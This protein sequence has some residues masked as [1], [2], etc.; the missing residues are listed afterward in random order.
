MTRNTNKA[1]HIAFVKE[2]VEMAS[3]ILKVF[4]KKY[5]KDKRPR[6]AIEAAKDWL[7]NP[8]EINRKAAEKAYHAVPGTAM[9]WTPADAAEA[10]CLAAY[11][12]STPDSF[13]RGL[14][15]SKS[16]ANLWLSTP[17]QRPGLRPRFSGR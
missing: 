9:P 13:Y 5:P 15:H 10:A 2:A 8:T 17:A 16:S 3:R 1:T 11:E 7:K 4:E 14:K 12:A 6:K